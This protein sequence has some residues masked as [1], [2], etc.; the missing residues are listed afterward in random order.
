V[1]PVLHLINTNEISTNIHVRNLPVRSSY[2]TS[3]HCS[4]GNEVIIS[5][6][7]KYS[8]DDCSIFHK[9]LKYGLNLNV[10]SVDEWTEKIMGHIYNDMMISLRKEGIPAI[11]GNMYEPG[12]HCVMRSKSCTVSA[13][14]L[15]HV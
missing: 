5:R 1:C 11:C 8:P 4:K 10:L 6:R 15:A 9:Y 12:E 3:E 13:S 7:Y 14:D 2:L